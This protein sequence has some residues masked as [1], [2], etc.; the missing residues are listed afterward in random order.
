MVTPKDVRCYAA[1]TNAEGITVALT[2]LAL[3]WALTSALERFHEARDAR[4]K[5]AAKKEVDDALE[6]LRK[7]RL[8]A[9][10]P[11]DGR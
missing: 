1:F 6:A 2:S 8:A 10:L 11:V 4:A 3:P 7:A 5:A 9:G